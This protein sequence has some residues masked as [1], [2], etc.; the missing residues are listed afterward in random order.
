MSI[1]SRRLSVFSLA[2]ALPV[3]LA[4]A[5]CDETKD[6]TPSVQANAQ[7][8]ASKPVSDRTYA[9]GTKISF[10]QGGNAARYQVSGW[11]A[12]ETE[13]CW[14]EGETAALAFILPPT[15]GDIVF[16]AT[17]S[18]FTKPPELPSQP[19]D[20]F[21]NGKQVTHWEIAVKGLV[22]MKVP[23]D[24]VR[25]GQ[26]QIEFKLPRASSPASLGVSVDQRRLGL[27]F[28]DL[29]LIKP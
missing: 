3:I 7:D 22:Q 4:C 17:M 20:V 25:D 1:L 24:F 16:K 26:L 23:A 15:D 14:T 6:E 2:V 19:V 5:G 29:E 8:P 9:Y 11:N 28:F 21:I 10:N 12:I 13:G 18:G 27:R